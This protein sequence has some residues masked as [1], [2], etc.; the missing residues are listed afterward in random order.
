MIAV[1][2]GGRTMGAVGPAPVGRT[3]GARVS[4]PRG[5]Q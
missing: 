5:E 3:I 1:V 2:N 4:D